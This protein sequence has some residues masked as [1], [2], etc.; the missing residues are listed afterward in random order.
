M[1]RLTPYLL[2]AV[3]MLSTGLG[4]GL[5][6]SGP[7]SHPL[8]TV[9]QGQP[10]RI[11]TEPIR[12]PIEVPNLLGLTDQAAATVVFLADLRPISTAEASSTVPASIVIA[13]APVPGTELAAGSR[14][15]ITMSGGP[16]WPG[17]PAS[18]P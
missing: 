8:A 7:S 15:L 17:V 16:S 10:H 2:I 6:L 13:Q 14:V 5:G 3:F 18:T 12:P 4:I 11:A 9:E 1:R